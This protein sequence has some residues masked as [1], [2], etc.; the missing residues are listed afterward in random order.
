MERRV[1]GAGDRTDKTYFFC[2]ATHGSNGCER[3]HKPRTAIGDI[4]HR[5][6]IS[7]EHR[8]QFT[9]LSN[10]R[11]AFVISDIAQLLHHGVGMAPSGFMVAAA[12]NK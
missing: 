3:F 1:K 5:G 11:Q 9:A 6:T 7:K 2:G 4:A 10:L 12:H 8:I